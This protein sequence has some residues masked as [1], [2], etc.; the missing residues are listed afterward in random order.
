MT[1]SIITILLLYLICSIDST[2]LEES[3]YEDRFYC[4]EDDGT[5]IETNERILVLSSE[6]HYFFQK[7]KLRNINGRYVPKDV[8]KT[9]ANVI[10]VNGFLDNDSVNG[11]IE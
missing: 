2:T 10:T 11:N 4:L 1:S 3:K 8:N 6:D 7:A 9:F 5:R